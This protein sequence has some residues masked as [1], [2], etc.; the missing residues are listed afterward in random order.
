MKSYKFL[1]LCMILALT[2]PYT[3]GGCAGG[4][5]SGGN[6]GNNAIS[7]SG[8]SEPAEIDE[9]NIEDLSGGALSA[10]LT[11]DV[12]VGLSLHKKG[13]HAQIDGNSAKKFRAVKIPGILS[14]SLDIIN[15][16]ISSAFGARAARKTESDMVTGN[17]GG[18]MSYSISVDETKGSFSGIFNF[19]EYCSDGTTVN[20]RANFSGRID[21]DTNE[22]LEANFSFDSMSGGGLIYDGDID[23][24]YSE[25]FS[26]LTFNAYGKDPN[27]GKVYWIKDYNIS[28]VENF[29]YFEAQMTGHFYHPDYGYVTLSSTGPFVVYDGDEWPT[30]GTFIITGAND[31]KAKIRA[32]D[33]LNCH[34]EADLEGDGLYEWDMGNKLWE[35]L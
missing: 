31:S 20:G 3:Y 33:H 34:M 26:E 10:G 35:D 28:I 21:I 12:M 24:Y 11:G 15:P 6:D 5:G 25:S 13:N 16:E 32:I 14:D 30:S 1:F 27:S 8:V 29:G 9:Q 17:C 22:F 4:G 2:L 18:S 19:S 23:I 7:Y